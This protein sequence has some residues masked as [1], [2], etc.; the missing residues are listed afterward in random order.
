MAVLLFSV[1]IAASYLNNDGMRP[2]SEEPEPDRPSD[3]PRESRQRPDP[4]ATL[5]QGPLGIYFDTANTAKYDERDGDG[6]VMVRYDNSLEYNPVT[7]AQYALAYHADFVKNGDPVSKATL[8]QY[9]DWLVRHQG[10]DGLWR[11]DFEFA[12]MARGWYSAL[13]EGQ[14]ISALARCYQVG[15]SVTYR[16]A[17]D[18]ALS[19]FTRPIADGGVVDREAG[20]D[21][22]E[23]YLPP[24]SRHT[25][26]GFIYAV[27]GLGEYT[28]V[29]GGDTSVRLYLA[30]I[31]TLHSNIG[32]W[33]SGVWS[34]YNLS[35]RVVHGER[36]PGTAASPY[37]HG[38]HVKQLRELFQLTGDSVFADTADRWAGYQERP[39]SWMASPLP[40]DRP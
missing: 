39:P 20:Y 17:S 27:I 4:T 28:A 9:C 16:R 10:A 35:P 36:W 7:I 29:F 18:L 15:G 19:T 32:R 11:Y 30:G 6:I 24:Y 25:L 1:A 26:N 34:T 40:S 38:L 3:N 22:Y 13:A 33:D 12:G 5:D 31:E 2:S 8:I 23:E 21:Y 14:A 37:Y